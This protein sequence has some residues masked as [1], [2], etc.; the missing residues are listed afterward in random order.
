LHA[1]AETEDEVEG[2]FLLDIVIGKSSA[3][4]ELFSGEDETLLVWWNSFFILDFGF[5]VVDGI[6]GFYLEG[7]GFA[8]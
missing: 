2:G 7:Y 6:G 1:A 8:G 3:V 5:D 4:F